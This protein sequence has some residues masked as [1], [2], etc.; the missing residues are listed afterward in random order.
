MIDGTINDDRA[1]AGGDKD[2][3]PAGRYH[4]LRKV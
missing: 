1:V 3:I 4:I 2:M